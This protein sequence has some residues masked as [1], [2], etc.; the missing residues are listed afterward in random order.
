[1]S[2]DAATIHTKFSRKCIVNNPN[3]W[4]RNYLVLAGALLAGTL[5]ASLLQQRSAPTETVVA[6]V[7]QNVTGQFVQEPPQRSS[8][9]PSFSRGNGLSLS[10]RRS[11][12]LMLRAFQDA[13]GGSWK[14]AV[15]I[16]SENEQV[17]L[18]AIVDADGWIV[19]KASQLPAETITCQLHDNRELEAEVVSQ[20][21][22]YDLAL[23][24]I[25]AQNLPVVQWDATI[26]N[27]GSWLATVDVKTTPSSVGVV[28]TGV[29]KVRKS[30]PVLGVH[31]ID[32]SEGAAVTRVLTGTGADEVG[33]RVGDSI[34]EVN[35]VEVY[36]LQAFRNVISS[37]AGGQRVKL[38]V[39]RADQ[40]FDVEARLMDLSEELL[41]DSEMEVNGRVSA[42][43]TGF[44]RVFFHDTVLEPQ[45]CGGPLVNLDGRVVGINIARAGRVTSYAL[46]SDVVQPVVK[47]L[48]D[49]AR[50]V[51]RNAE[52][53]NSLRPIR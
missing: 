47:N 21:S 37:T 31:L 52:A 39:N 13:I 46:P 26:P 27:R 33:L 29:Q 15:R 2:K 5:V 24:R 7:D 45:Q 42:R 1:M 20:V 32:S 34:Y 49:Q 44:D 25:P 3:S 22:D 41:D 9:R 10:N 11:N 53:A 19:T 38:G 8:F 51:S 17:A 28:S 4:L 48:I 14:S 18:G 12:F 40:K 35:G 50:L 30:N 6:E 36:T 23:L 16:F 43:A